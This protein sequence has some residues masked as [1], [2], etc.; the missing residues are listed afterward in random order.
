VIGAGVAGKRSGIGTGTERY[1]AI[2]DDAKV[3]IVM[4]FNS[5]VDANTTTV[6]TDAS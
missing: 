5:N 3:R 4:G 2:N 6:V 1:A